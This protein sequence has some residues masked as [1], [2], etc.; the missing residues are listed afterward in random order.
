MTTVAVIIP[1]LGTAPQRLRRTVDAVLASRASVNLD[2]VVV[3]NSSQS[4]AQLDLPQSVRAVEAGANLG[5]AGGLHL[6]RAAATAELLWLVQDDMVPDPV[7]LQQ[8]INELDRTGAALVSPVTVREAVYDEA[9]AIVG[10]LA[11]RHALGARLNP[12]VFGA[13]DGVAPSDAAEGERGIVVDRFP[14]HDLVLDALSV[15]DDLDYVPSRGMLLASHTWD[16]VGGMDPRNYPVG[17]SDVEFCI[18]LAAAGLRF[19]IAPL[20]RATHE[21]SASTPK[22]LARAVF[23]RNRR[24]IVETWRDGMPRDATLAPELPPS[25]RDAVLVGA[26]E[27]VAA[28]RDEIE[29]VTRERDA[30]RIRVHR[31]TGD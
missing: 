20:A 26:T 3:V 25:V 19:T 24:R 22:L 27:A 13:I 10:G 12:A 28:L 15:P 21:V 6:G 23:R 11:P 14:P 18:A 5:W 7:C 17:G 8:L 30:L 31:L 16:S 2:V 29:R 4:A 1:T 9:G